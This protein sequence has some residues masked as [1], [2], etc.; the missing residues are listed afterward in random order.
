[1][2]LTA[3]LLWYFAAAAALGLLTAL[4]DSLWSTPDAASYYTHAPYRT[5]LYPAI[6]DLTDGDMGLWVWQLAAWVC[7]V[8]LTAEAARSGWAA[9]LLAGNL[10]LVALTGHALTEVWAVLIVAAGLWAYDR[11]CWYGVATALILLTW[12]KPVVPVMNE[13]YSRFAEINADRFHAHA[14]LAGGPV[15]SYLHNMGNAIVARSNFVPRS[16]HLFTLMY[17]SLVWLLAVL[18]GRD[19]WPWIFVGFHVAAAGVTFGQGDRILMPMMPVL[20]Y[21][22]TRRR[23]AVDRDAV[24]GVISR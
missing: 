11:R 7:A 23:D 4:P 17:T 13:Q 3:L 24:A 6:I 5:A 10:G 20:V 9:V 16:W 8:L 15:L 2:R 1:M 12:L 22:I 18:R 21:L 19:K 14:K